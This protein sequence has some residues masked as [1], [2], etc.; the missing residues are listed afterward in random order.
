[1]ELEE[2]TVSVGCDKGIKDG[3]LVPAGNLWVPASLLLLPIL[4][5]FYLLVSVPEEGDGGLEC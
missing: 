5:G 3:G 4:T 1:M 2:R